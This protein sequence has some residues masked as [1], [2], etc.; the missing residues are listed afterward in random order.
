MRRGFFNGM[1]LIVGRREQVLHEVYVGMA[2]PTTVLHVA[3]V[4]KWSAAAAIAALVDEG[5]LSWDDPVNEYLPEFAGEKGRA[6]LRQ[7]LSHTAGYP[8]YQ[9]PGARRDDYP[10]LTE[11]VAHI[12]DLPAVS[13]PGVAFQYG[14]LA[15]QVAGRM[16]EVAAAQSFEEIFQ[17]RIARPLQMRRSGYSPVS[18]EPGFSPMLGGSL[19]TSTRDYARLLMMI[20]QDGLYQGKRILSSRVIAEMQADQVRGAKLKPGEFVERTR[21]EVRGDIYGLGEWREEVDSRGTATVISSPGWAGAYAWLDKRLDVW[22]MVL[23]KAN[24]SIAERAGYSPFLG[25][26]VYMPLVREIL[27][28]GRSGPDV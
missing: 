7:L 28:A 8:D 21:G 1:G 13:Q 11:S 15:M 19:F 4:G 16:A 10:T 23:A 25:S 24:V 12:V 18:T 3:S 9:P 27:K 2:R 14:G 5:K 20:A 6:R 22:G 26:S 17:S